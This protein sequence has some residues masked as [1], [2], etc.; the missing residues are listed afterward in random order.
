MPPLCC[1][2]ISGLYLQIAHYLFTALSITYCLLFIRLIFAGRCSSAI[3]PG[4]GVGAVL[5]TPAPKQR[6]GL[7]EQQRVH[8]AQV[9]G[10]TVDVLLHVV[11]HD[12][13]HLVLVE[14]QLLAPGQLHHKP[15]ANLSPHVQ[16][17]QVLQLQ[18]L[19]QNVGLALRI[20][21]AE[22]HKIQRRAAHG[23]R[24][25]PRR[26][27]KVTQQQVAFEA[28]DGAVVGV[29]AQHFRQPGSGHARCVDLP[30]VA[31]EHAQVFAHV[32]SQ[33]G[34]GRAEAECLHVAPRGSSGCRWQA[35]WPGIVWLP[36]R[37]NQRLR[38]LLLTLRSSWASACI[39]AHAMSAWPVASVRDAL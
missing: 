20:P 18:H 6:G 9:V 5:V 23:L 37:V 33:H 28:R 3:G 14:V 10:H 11:V 4:P 29:G 32:A 16:R 25:A 31:G 22:H 26:R 13:F 1:Y 21:L 34:L 36:S 12:V 7:V 17:R 30:V 39:T 15:A 19:A 24:T 35:V 38:R 2:G 8:A 27:Y